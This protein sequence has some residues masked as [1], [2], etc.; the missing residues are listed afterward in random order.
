MPEVF[1]KAHLQVTIV[2]EP[3][4]SFVSILVMTIIVDKRL[5]TGYFAIV[6]IDFDE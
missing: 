6:M 2:I 1:F 5:I 3:G 4:K